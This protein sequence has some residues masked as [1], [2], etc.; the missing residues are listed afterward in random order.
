MA[1]LTG[2]GSA[3]TAGSSDAVAVDALGALATVADR[4]VVDPVLEWL[5]LRSRSDAVATAALAMLNANAAS[6][7]VDLADRI[8]SNEATL[9]HFLGAGPVFR[10][11]ISRT[12]VV[13]DSV[14]GRGLRDLVGRRPLAYADKLLGAAAGIPI[15]G[16]LTHVWQAAFEQGKDEAADFVVKR[17]LASPGG[18]RAGRIQAS[19]ATLP[20]YKAT[21]LPQLLQALDRLE[22]L[23]TDTPQQFAT[24]RDGLQ[25]L[26]SAA[27]PRLRT[28]VEAYEAMLRGDVVGA[29]S[30]PPFAPGTPGTFTRSRSFTPMTPLRAA[31]LALSVVPFLATLAIPWDIPPGA[32]WGKTLLSRALTWLTDA[33]ILGPVFMY[34][35]PVEVDAG[36]K[37]RSPFQTVPSTDQMLHTL[38]P[39]LVFVAIFGFPELHRW[40]VG[41]LVLWH[42]A[43]LFAVNLVGFALATYAI[44]GGEV[45]TR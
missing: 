24:V 18:G 7:G 11:L 35:F 39:L 36:D 17:L 23:G 15:E 45:S 37:W 13:L 31:A 5:R 22:R 6:H 12:P 2:T 25:A 42:Q 8:V 20:D 1:V 29:S 10:G 41:P 14:L 34:L 43:V 26:A 21:V 9:R 38:G 4:D 30:F 32:G 28:A 44:T 16:L 3:G 40:W 33:A 19:L 27:R